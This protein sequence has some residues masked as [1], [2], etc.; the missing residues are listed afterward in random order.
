MSR[1][2]ILFVIFTAVL[3]VGY[4][5]RGPLTS[6]FFQWYL[7]SYCRSCLGAKLTYDGIRH[8]NGQ[9][10]IQT[11]VLTTQ[12]RLENG[13]YSFQAEKAMVLVSVSWLS[14][15]LNLDVAIASPHIDIGTGAEDI[16][17]IFE[18]Q[19]ETFFFNI[20]TN[21]NIPKGTI[22]VHDFNEEHL[23]PI[24]LFFSIDFKARKKKEGY[25][26][27]WLGK[28]DREKHDFLAVFTQNEG[29]KA[30][31]ALDFS[32]VDC[33]PL[34]QVLRGLWPKLSAFEIAQ[35]KLGG[36]LAFSFPEGS[37][38]SAEGQVALKD[39][40]AHHAESGVE[41]R[42][43][44]IKLNLTPSQLP[45]EDKSRGTIGLIESLPGSIVVKAQDEPFWSIQEIA[46]TASF[47]TCDEVKFAFTGHVDSPLNRRQMSIK[48]NGRF[49]EPGQTS[50]AID[51]ELVG[52][53]PEEGTAFHLSTRELGE[54]WSFGEVELVQFGKEELKIIQHF[55]ADRASE[56][57][58]FQIAKGNIDASALVYLKG[59]QLSEVH[60]ERLAA[61]GLEFDFLP[62]N[63]SGRVSRGEGSLSF[64][65][66]SDE[67]LNTLNASININQ[68]S[69]NLEGLERAVW[70]FSGIDANLA[71][72]RGVV[73]K[74]VLKG[75]IAGLKGEILI[76]GTKPGPIAELHFQ[77]KAIDFSQALPDPIR[78]GI[79]KEFSQDGLTVFAELT[80]LPEM[81]QFDGKI[82]VLEGDQRS[83]E[84]D[85]GF[86]LEKSSVGLW[87]K[88]PP[89]P[90]AADYFSGPG[91]EAV[92]MSVPALAMPVNVVYAHLIKEK[93]GF[94]AFGVKNGWFQAKNL[95]LEKFLTPFIFSKNQMRLSGL[96]DFHGDS[97]GQKLV[98]RYDARQMIL[99]NSDFAAEIPKLHQDDVYS[100]DLTPTFVYDFDKQTYY[101]SLPIHNG[102]Y[103]EKNTGLLFTE[104]NGKVSM[105]DATC[106]LFGLNTFCNGLCFDGEI[107]L[108]WSM[109]GDGIF[110]VAIQLQGMHGKVSHLKSFLFHINPDILLLKVPLEGNVSL[111][112]SGSPLL[113]SFIEGGYEFQTRF[114]GKLADGVMSGQNIDMSVNDISLNFEY[115]HAGNTLDFS[116]IQGTLLVGK[117]NHI[118]EYS[119][120][121]NKFRF[122][123][124]RN[125]ASEFDFIVGDKTRHIARLVGSTSSE[126][127]GGEPMLTFHVDKALSHF[128]N[129][130]PYTFQMALK[131]WSQVDV[132]NLEFEFQLESLLDDLKRFSRTG[133]FFLSRN[134]LKELHEVTHAKGQFTTKI[135]YDKDRSVIQYQIAGY[136]VGL[137]THS[138]QR[139]HLSGTKKDNL[140]SI[141]QLQL[142]DISLACDI[143]KESSIWNINFFGARIGSS[144]TIGLEGKYRDEDA[145]LEAKINVLE[146]NLSD[147]STWPAFQCILGGQQLTGE[148]RAVGTVYAEFDKTTPCGMQIDAKMTGSLNNGSYK[149][150]ILQDIHGMSFSY[151]TDAGFSIN[152]VETGL[153]SSDQ[154]L[155]AKI[156]LKGASFNSATHEAL[157]SGLHFDIPFKN[158]EWVSKQLQANFSTGV[159]DNA[160]KYIQKLKSAGSVQGVID[161]AISSSESRCTLRFNDG[162]YHLMGKEHEVSQPLLEYTH[163]GCT[164][165]ANY[166]H[167]GQF[168]RIEA[169]SAAPSFDHGEIVISEMGR[170]PNGAQAMP[171]II[172]WQSDCEAGFYIQRMIGTISG[173]TFDLGRMPN[174]A[175]SQDAFY[176]TG[177]VDINFVAASALMDAPLSFNVQNFELGSGYSLL[178]HWNISKNEALSLEDKIQF[179]G[180]L[181]GN[182]FELMGYRFY[183]LYSQV[184]YNPKAVS[185]RNLRVSDSCGTLQVGQ[186][187]FIDKGCWVF[188]SPQL[189]ITD[190]RPSFLRSLRP[191]SFKRIGKSLIIRHLEVNHLQ[192]ILGD[193]NSITG[194]GHLNFINPPKKNLQHPIFIIPAELLAR[195]GLDMSV[196]TPVRGS[197]FYE[198]KNGRASLTK[199]KDI[200]SKGKLSK[201]NLAHNGYDSYVDFDGNIHAEVRMKQYNLIFKLAELFTVTVQGTLRKPTY[202]LQKQTH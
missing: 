178:G 156:F 123:D 101:N 58:Q 175:L 40:V 36:K 160:A 150:F 197:I 110:D 65:L 17:S 83:G 71:I 31:L 122:T 119:I 139:F 169:R 35:G 19:S 54:H 120:T 99:E 140:W 100:D 137:K 30:E 55:A 190:F 171:L 91:L 135:S 200:Y 129:V 22:L 116:D 88:W 98:V 192:G 128:G 195:L 6:Q 167:K 144:L 147:L 85:F 191:S 94:G 126:L 90:I 74:S 105:E 21:L 64:D 136:D 132:F 121:G 34:Q 1:K 32:N 78:K 151:R 82:I 97:D 159:A 39:L 196:L 45:K 15:S 59:L 42:V 33:L 95:K 174:A 7:K 193:K 181:L 145:G 96:G 187:D 149:G 158:L 79:E 47:Q 127:D 103:F 183:S 66:L 202:T 102:T 11:P 164:V 77:G 8:E 186:A 43:P 73:Q 173:L 5:A 53:T 182:E 18:R 155:G 118:E 189:V 157:V 20:Y 70:E 2:W 113:F 48:G 131:D 84:I 201:F 69:L 141:E 198:L 161:A 146:A 38:A 93:L 75:M 16:R 86:A 109:P 80:K 9:W 111:Q 163:Y 29:D 125:H 24:P 46:G 12:K 176:L 172:H 49:A 115:D 52:K 67:P 3:T 154:E 107:D 143:L 25:A 152:D 166:R 188:S 165:S 62:W 14:R 56:W 180:E 112:K 124:Y 81:L 10:I 199:F 72:S 61:S 13:G 26:S 44:S 162:I 133:L 170:Y 37:G 89:H 76:D 148:V 168:F 179:Q 106:H 51:V 117:A 142:D 104:I 114:F 153:K 87:H 23:V 68:A 92:R 63:L 138:F 57:L 50:F 28:E 184:A 41:I 27:L 4:A 108:D 130:H 60:V 134:M 185:L 177:K 194:V